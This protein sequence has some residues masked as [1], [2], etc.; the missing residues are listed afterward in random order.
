MF[1]KYSGAINMGIYPLDER[2]NRY[3]KKVYRPSLAIR[4]G[5]TILDL[6]IPPDMPLYSVTQ[7]KKT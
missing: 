3:S 5:S 4:E 7:V 6:E 1:A 2:E